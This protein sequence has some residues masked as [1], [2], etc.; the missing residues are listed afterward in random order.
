MED[1]LTGNAIGH[2]SCVFI[3]C[4]VL[5]ELTQPASCACWAGMQLHLQH[6]RTWIF[7]FCPRH[8]GNLE[9]EVSRILS[10]YCNGTGIFS[11]P[12]SGLKWPHGSMHDLTRGISEQCSPASFTHEDTWNKHVISSCPSYP[13][14]FDFPHPSQHS[15]CCLNINLPYGPG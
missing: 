11:W 9:T 7:S 8:L 10:S 13:P 1:L 5:L 2:G 6:G 15:V 3:T 14:V 4:S 12:F